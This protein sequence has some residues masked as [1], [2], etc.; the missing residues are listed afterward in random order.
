MNSEPLS[1]IASIFSD[2]N[3]SMQI[4]W[5]NSWIYGCDGETECRDG[6]PT[7]VFRWR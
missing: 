5:S 2:S 6:L 1:N 4:D 7:A 3:A